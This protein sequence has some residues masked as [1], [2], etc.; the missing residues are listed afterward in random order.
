MLG[1]ETASA[2]EG[3]CELLGAQ[4]ASADALAM[5]RRADEA[6]ATVN[7]YHD[8]AFRKARHRSVPDEKTGPLF[9][10]QPE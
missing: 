10:C 8:L 2:I 6:S 4:H 7:S 5:L 9:Y 3:R 1:E